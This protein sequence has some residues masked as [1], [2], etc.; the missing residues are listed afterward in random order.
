[1][2]TWSRHNI[3]IQLTASTTL[4]DDTGTHTVEFQPIAQAYSAGAV[5]G[6]QGS[7]ELSRWS[8][9]SDLSST[10]IYDIYLSGVR[11]GRLFGMDIVGNIEF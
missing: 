2:A 5:V 9:A 10:D 1:M 4:A 8:P 3:V 7:S 6:T 11:V